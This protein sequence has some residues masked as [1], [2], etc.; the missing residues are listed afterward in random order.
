MCLSGALVGRAGTVAMKHLARFPPGQAHQITFVTT[1]REPRVRESMPQLVRMEALDTGLAA[2]VPYDPLDSAVGHG[3]HD[4]SHRAF[5]RA[6]LWR[7]L[8]RMYRSRL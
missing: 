2:A 6:S 5:R 8:A 7:A 4:P 1:L 3:A